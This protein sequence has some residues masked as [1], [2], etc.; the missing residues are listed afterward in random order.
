MWQERKG[1]SYVAGDLAGRRQRLGIEQDT[2]LG[3]G[4]FH[5]FGHQACQGLS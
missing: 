5:C 3:Q 2:V 1:S 4:L